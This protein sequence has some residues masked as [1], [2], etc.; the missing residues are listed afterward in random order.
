MSLAALPLGG[1]LLGP[2]A[3]LTLGLSTS[4]HCALMCA[5][6]TQLAG[7]PAA[8]SSLQL[9]LGRLTAYALLGALAGGIGGALLL[10]IDGVGLRNALHVVAALLLLAAAAQRW[11]Q[12][13]PRPA[14]C[15]KP[16]IAQRAHLPPYVRGLLWGLLPCPLLYAVLGLSVLAGSAW[17]GAGLSLSFGLG[18]LP[19]LLVAT[20]L[21]AMLARR[22]TPLGLRRAGALMLGLSGLWI[23][24]ASP[25]TAGSISIFCRGG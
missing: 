25:L 15:I 6:M 10:V 9:H 21:G 2:L 17:L 12:P 13:A 19:L 14:C 24:A 1:L 8:R 20:G 5:P 4:P 16:S 23:A 22:L 7:N 3:M 18:T 11:R